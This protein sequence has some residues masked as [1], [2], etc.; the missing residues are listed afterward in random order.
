LLGL[1]YWMIGMALPVFLAVVSAVAWLIPWLGVGLA[2]IPVI[3]LG[4]MNG[5]GAA[6]LAVVYTLVVYSVVESVIEPR[7]VRRRYSSLLIVLTMIALANLFGL[8]GIVFAPPLAVGLQV[9]I[10]RRTQSAAL[11]DSADMAHE[12]SSLTERLAA[13]RVLLDESPEPPGPQ[14][15]HLTGRLARLLERARAE[16][17]LGEPDE[18]PSAILRA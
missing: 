3:L 13:V 17:R 7:L 14:A 18:P 16:L 2:L 12:I 11:A 5:P 9:F 6:A 15:V 10:G 1:G 8:A 4:W